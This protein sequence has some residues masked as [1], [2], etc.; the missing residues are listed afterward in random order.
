MRLAE[1]YLE[2]GQLFLIL[3]LNCCCCCFGSLSFSS[4]PVSETS[5]S[6]NFAGATTD[7]WT[8]L[9]RQNGKKWGLAGSL[10]FNTTNPDLVVLVRELTQNGFSW[11][12]GG[13]PQ[14]YL[15]YEEDNGT[16]SESQCE[17]GKIGGPIPEKFLCLKRDRFKGNS[18]LP[19]HSVELKWSP[20]RCVILQ[21]S[22]LLMVDL[23]R[24]T[25]V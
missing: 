6:F 18:W 13:T 14:D 25:L 16:W 24:C 20:K 8:K 9:N 15:F 21:K 2:M 5:K 12:I 17:D 22:C 23:Y 10:T 4:S 3:L 11:R 1:L 7:W 19:F